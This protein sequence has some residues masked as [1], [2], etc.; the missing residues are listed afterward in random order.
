MLCYNW[1]RLRIR[2][3]LQVGKNI[4]QRSELFASLWSLMLLPVPNVHAC[5]LSAH[6]R[7]RVSISASATHLWLAA[8]PLS[9]PGAGTVS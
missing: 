5:V 1:L 4:Q 9:P 8:T 3:G 2:K 7:V 6:A